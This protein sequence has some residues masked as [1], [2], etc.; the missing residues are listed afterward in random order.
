VDSVGVV[1]GDVFAEKTLQVLFIQDDHVVKKL[2]AGAANPSL[3]DPILPRASK[4]RSPRLDS[5][6]LDRLSDPL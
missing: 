3:G 1:V 5:N 6:I 4:S 2:P